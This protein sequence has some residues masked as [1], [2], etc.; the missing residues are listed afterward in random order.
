MATAGNCFIV[1]WR[2]PSTR[3][4]T[5]GL[6]YACVCGAPQHGLPC[7]RENVTL[8]FNLSIARETLSLREARQHLC[9]RL[10]FSRVDPGSSSCSG[11]GRTS[12]DVDGTPSVEQHHFEHPDLVC[13]AQALAPAKYDVSTANTF[14]KASQLGELK[15]HCFEIHSPDPRL[16]SLSSPFCRIIAINPFVHN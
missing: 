12:S 14:I 8:F 7:Y 5:P 9:R 15:T 10:P 13:S 11:H 4:A 1:V 16:F 2:E 3:M 6:T